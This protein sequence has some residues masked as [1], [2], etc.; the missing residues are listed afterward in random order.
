MKSEN[1]SICFD[2]SSLDINAGGFIQYCNALIPLMNN[3][4]KQGLK[5][6]IFVGSKGVPLLIDALAEEIVLHRVNGYAKIKRQ[7]HFASATYDLVLFLGNV[8]TVL[9]KSKCISVIHDTKFLDLPETV[10]LTKRIYRRTMLWFTL[11]N[12]HRF[13]AISNFTK[14]SFEQRLKPRQNVEVVHTA[15]NV[16]TTKNISVLPSVNNAIVCVSTG[17]VH[18]QT[19]LFVKIAR[20]M[21]LKYFVLVSNEHIQ[22]PPANMSFLRNLTRDELIATL[23]SSSVVVCPSSYEGLGMVFWEAASLGKPICATDLP[24]YKEINYEGATLLSKDDRVLAW[25][26]AIEDSLKRKKAK[27]NPV[28]IGRSM[29]QKYIRIIY[30][31]IYK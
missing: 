18:K 16:E 28:Q 9:T 22:D 25:V 29:Q 6:T 20:N 5:V 17:F 30:D 23:K 10:T 7:F 12:T 1:Y 8:S 27:L 3:L 26:Q 14:N 13:I 15:I 4:S 24:V 2:M 21:P 19:D 31:E 11:R